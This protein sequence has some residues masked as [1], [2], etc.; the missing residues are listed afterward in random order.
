MAIDLWYQGPHNNRYKSARLTHELIEELE[1]KLE[2]L[3][4]VRDRYVPML[5]DS[6]YFWIHTDY[7]DVITVEQGYITS[8]P[9]TVPAFKLQLFRYRRPGCGD[10]IKSP[11]RRTA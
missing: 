7:G 8:Y 1:G 11:F 2:L 9:D 6:S 4:Y 10:V 3:G 5:E